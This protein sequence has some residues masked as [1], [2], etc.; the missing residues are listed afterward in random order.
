MIDNAAEIGQWLEEHNI[1]KY[2]INEDLSVDVDG[3]VILNNL[4]LTELP[5]QFNI[6]KTS[7]YLN[8]N[9]LTTLKGCPRQ[10][11]GHFII[12][13]N[14][15]V[16]L[17]YCPEIIKGNF[18]CKYNKLESLEY[19]PKTVGR[20]Y[21][22]SHNYLKSL[23]HSPEHIGNNFDC[24]SNYIE[25]LKY[26]PKTIDGDLLVSYQDIMLIREFPTK[27]KGNFIHAVKKN[28]MKAGNVIRTLA[29]YYEPEGD[30]Y[31]VSLS[32]TAL[33]YII[34]H[35]NLNKSIRNKKNPANNKNKI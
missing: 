5:V 34:M 27:L 33:S 15:L 13:H 31:I 24:G 21:V 8:D 10:L 30:K 22:C 29:D 11:G 20:D 2:L 28:D 35:Q 26:L 25:D 19:G 18:D 17:E 9:K 6:I 16:S 1:T 7:L 3:A 32:A 14:E 12:D 4:G 23:E